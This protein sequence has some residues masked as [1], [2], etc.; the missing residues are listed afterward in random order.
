MVLIAVEFAGNILSC[1]KSASNGGQWSQWD[2]TM[3][4]GR[5]YV[6]SVPKPLI[7]VCKQLN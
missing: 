2:T 5:V 4:N 6:A 3:Q 7:T 1:K